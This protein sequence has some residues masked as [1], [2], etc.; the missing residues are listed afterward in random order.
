[1]EQLLAQFLAGAQADEFD[2]DVAAGPQPGEPDHL[3]G[4]IDDF[5]RLAHVEDADLAA[6]SGASGSGRQSRRLQHQLDRLA[7]GHEKTR[8]LGMGDGQR[9]AGRELAREQRHHRSGGAQHI[10]EAHGDIARAAGPPCRA[11]WK[12][13][14]WQKLSARRLVAPMTLVGL[15]A[16][17]VE[18]MTTIDTPNV[19]AASA[20]LRL[21]A[22]LV[23][24][25]SIGLA[26]TIGRCFSA[27]A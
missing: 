5:D 13:S 11:S 25:P 15:T 9:S 23:R 27:A 18:I 19:R 3:L 1:M 22:T 20:T 24:T 14:A 10:A 2:L 26:S 21:P 6:R 7:Y 17:S 4:E 16:L 8:D 12:S